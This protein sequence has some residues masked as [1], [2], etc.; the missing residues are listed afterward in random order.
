MKKLILI[1]ASIVF[2]AASM[3]IEKD[4]TKITIREKVILIID[5]SGDTSDIVLSDTSSNV[6]KRKRATRDS[7]WA[8]FDLGV[9]GFLTPDGSTS[10]DPKD[11]FLDLNYSKSVVVN[12]NPFE[13]YI[14][15]KGDR[16]GILTGLGFQFNSY[17]LKTNNRLITT[18]STDSTKSQLSSFRDSLNMASV[19]KNKFK[20]TYLTVPIL[21]EYNDAKLARKGFHF[22]AGMVFG[23]RIGSK[24]KM[25]YTTPSGNNKKDKYRDDFN[26]NPFSMALTTRFGVGWV[27]LFATYNLSPLFEKDKGPELYPFTVG[28]TLLDF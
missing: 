5:E 4:T 28:I 10:L 21:F 19:S 16:F 7:H 12:L 27:N 8:G 18:P 15:I 24:N 14:P 22:S 6:S 13:K 1:I 26:L 20:A 11:S 25:K 17:D 3:A 9:N 2:S 23:Y